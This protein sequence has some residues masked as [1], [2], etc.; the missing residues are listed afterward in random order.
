MN[1]INIFNVANFF[2]SIVDR[3]A[4]STI[5]P[6]KLQKILYYAQGYY[7]AINNNELF[8]EEF[9]AWAHGPANPE[10]YDKYKGYGC[11]AISEPSEKDMPNFEEDVINFLY[12]IW[13]TF[14]IYDGKYLEELTHQESPWIEARKGYQ[15]GEVCNNIITKDSMK[16]FFKTKINVQ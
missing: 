16:V 2:L 4:G 9:E 14:G 13:N 12:D 11:S 1:K 7:L 3:D 15:P 10:I 5:T 8:S 6:L